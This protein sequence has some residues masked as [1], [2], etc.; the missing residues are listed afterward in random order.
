MLQLGDS[1][2]AE[3]IANILAII[4]CLWYT[5]MNKDNIDF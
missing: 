1:A 4:F 5:E 3:D 2:N